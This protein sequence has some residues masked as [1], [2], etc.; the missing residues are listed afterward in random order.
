MIGPDAVAA[1]VNLFAEYLLRY[2]IALAGVGA[3]AMAL[4]EAWKKLFDT[5]TKYHM[6]AVLAW[7]GD[8][9]GAYSELIHLTTGTL[10]SSENIHDRHKAFSVKRKS[11]PADFQ[12]SL[13]TLELERMMGHI[14]D[15]ATMAL[16][17]WR[18]FPQLFAFLT[19]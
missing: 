13:F 10:P 7:F 5:R 14:Q 2:A 19:S 11:L 9:H 4:I 8:A 16:R 6:R 17:D 18:T 12:L 1:A 15:A 3:L